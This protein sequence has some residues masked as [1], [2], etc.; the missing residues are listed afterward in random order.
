MTFTCPTRIFWAGGRRRV[1]GRSGQTG[2]S[3]DLPPGPCRSIHTSGEPLLW[4][5]DGLANPSC[6]S[7]ARAPLSAGRSASQRPPATQIFP[8]FSRGS[9]LSRALRTPCTE[10]ETAAEEAQNPK[11]KPKAAGGGSAAGR[12]C[13][14]APAAAR[15]GSPFLGKIT[16]ILLQPPTLHAILP[17]SQRTR[18]VWQEPA[19]ATAPDFGFPVFPI[20]FFFFF[21][22]RHVL[23]FTIPN[24]N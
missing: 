16:Q 21:F 10:N 12:A 8:F 15:R 13:G 23:K 4:L 17:W 5:Q 7:A 20:D 18:Q 11:L 6:P 2:Q 14:C 1:S 3:G 22:T 24:Q 19:A 9:F